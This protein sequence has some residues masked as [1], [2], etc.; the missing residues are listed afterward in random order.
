M[1]VPVLISMTVSFT[2]IIYHSF[3]A[4]RQKVENS[5]VRHKIHK[6]AFGLVAFFFFCLL[7]KFIQPI[8]STTSLQ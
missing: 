4:N 2:P 6:N 3:V 5:S 8:E 7:T 1:V